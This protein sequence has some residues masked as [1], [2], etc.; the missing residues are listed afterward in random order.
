MWPLTY[1][2]L[3]EKLKCTISIKNDVFTLFSKLRACNVSVVASGVIFHAGK[4]VFSSKAVRRGPGSPK[5]VYVWKKW[6]VGNVFGCFWCV[7][8]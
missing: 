1:T 2:K 6:I 4:S 7:L 5:L 8:Y 3:Y